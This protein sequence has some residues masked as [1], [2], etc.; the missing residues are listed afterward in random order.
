MEASTLSEKNNRTSGLHRESHKVQ[1]AVQNC[2]T[3][4]QLGKCASF[5]SDKG[6][7]TK[8]NPKMIQMLDLT[9]KDYDWA[10]GTVLI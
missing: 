10:C 2:S 5:F 8:H 7:L 6:Q 9:S 3:C 4:E 1:E